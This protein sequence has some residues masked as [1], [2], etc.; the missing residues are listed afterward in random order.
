M[1]TY[2]ET[3]GLPIVIGDTLDDLLDIAEHADNLSPAFGFVYHR[4]DEYRWMI[5]Y[6]P[7][8]WPPISPDGPG[9]GDHL[10]E[11]L[12]HGDHSELREIATVLDL[13][14]WLFTGS[15]W[16]VD[17]RWPA[18]EGSLRDHPHRQHALTSI[19]LDQHDA[20]I[21]KRFQFD[22][23]TF[24]LHTSTPPAGGWTLANAGSIIAAMEL[25]RTSTQADPHD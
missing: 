23:G 4:D 13:R 6:G 14:G 25:M 17:N 11:Q 12:R 24:E 2:D 10:Y 15:S 21:T 20:T 8:A 9:V 1:P 7:D 5:M 16:R 3:Q 22:D 18:R 19:H